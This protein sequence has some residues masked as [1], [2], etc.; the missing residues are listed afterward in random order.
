MIEHLK[1]FL[2]YLENERGLSARTLK[3]YRRDLEQLL[4]FLQAEE[5]NQP[6]QVTQHQAVFVAQTGTGKNYCSHAR[7]RYVHGE[8]RW[9][10]QGLTGLNNGALFNTGPKIHAGRSIG[11][12]RGQRD[13]LT[14]S[15]VNYF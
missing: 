12:M 3:A 5:I 14:Q 6:N 1:N 7:I 2:I 11:G 10:Q 15:R 13:F 4:G 9:Y 8:T